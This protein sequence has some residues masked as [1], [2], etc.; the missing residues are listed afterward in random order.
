MISLYKQVA[1]EYTAS[2]F[3]DVSFNVAQNVTLREARSNIVQCC[4][5]MEGLAVIAKALVD[6][7][8]F[9]LKIL[10]LIIQKSGELQLFNYQN[11]CNKN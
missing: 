11:M 7:E 2:E 6:D 8:H 1:D 9:L 4:I 10:Y 5:L 3:W